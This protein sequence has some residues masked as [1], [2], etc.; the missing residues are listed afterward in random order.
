MAPAA[1]EAKVAFAPGAPFFVIEKPNHFP[2]LNFSNQAPERI[3]N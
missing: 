1:I 3:K 2:R